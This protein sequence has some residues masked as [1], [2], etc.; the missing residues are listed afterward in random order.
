MSTGPAHRRHDA[1]VCV[2]GACRV[3]WS[4]PFPA[5]CRLVDNVDIACIGMVQTRLLPQ[6]A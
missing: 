2:D 4:A 6:L 1:K 3:V 5:L